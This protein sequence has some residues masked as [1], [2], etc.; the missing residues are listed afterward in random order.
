MS[1]VMFVHPYEERQY[2][3]FTKEGWNI[4]DN[5][6]EADVVQFW[7]GEDVDG[8][9]YGRKNH[10][11][12]TTNRDRDVKERALFRLCYEWGKPMAGICRGA[13]FLN[14]MCGGDLWQDI[15]MHAIH[16]THGMKDTMYNIN[17]QV[18]ST[19]HQAM[20]PTQQA[21]VIGKSQISS[22][23]VSAPRMGSDVV[24]DERGDGDDI[25]VV[26]YEEQNVLCCQPH[27][28]Y[29][30]GTQFQSTYFDYLNNFL[31]EGNR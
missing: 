20:R 15:N 14:V 28:E 13:Q 25:E 9:I 30:I 16:G 17:Y 27:P 18:T 21:Y 11:T 31:L 29:Q 12:M 26:W 2:D 19:H 22:R 10:S 6:S 4:V 23:R 8:S 5:I 24:D 7:G 3:M 1:N